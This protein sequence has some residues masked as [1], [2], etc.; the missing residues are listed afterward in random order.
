MPR[1]QTVYANSSCHVGYP[2]G[3]VVYVEAGQEWLADD[4]LVKARPDLFRDDAPEGTVHGR[5]PV[6]TATAE[7]GE[8]RTTARTTKKATKK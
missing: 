8:T 6:E 5:A 3:G 1:P 4:P 2:G 7:P